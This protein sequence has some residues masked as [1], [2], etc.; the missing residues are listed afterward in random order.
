MDQMCRIQHVQTNVA[1]RMN[2]N[3]MLLERLTGSDMKVT[4]HFIHF[5]MSM[6]S[7]TFIRWSGILD[8]IRS[9]KAGSFSFSHALLH[10]G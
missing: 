1:E 4:G 6:K 9:I 8:A 7:T 2:V 3:V 10:T 5:Q